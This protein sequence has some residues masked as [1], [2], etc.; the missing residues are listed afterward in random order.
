LKRALSKLGQKFFVLYGD[1][2]LPIDYAAVATGFKTSGK[3]A[4]MTVFKNENRW[5]SSNVTFDGK[6]IRCYDKKNRTAE[7]EYI[8]YGLG[9]F[10]KEALAEWP[11]DKPFDLADVYRNLVDR[12]QLA[13]F[14]VKQRFYEAGSPAGLAEL[15]SVLRDPT[16]F[17]QT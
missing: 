12:S 9:A 2:Y 14:E 13:G 8:D 17:L 6:N 5:D 11:D 15:D 1:S 4:L 10:K 3:L 16:T 7:M